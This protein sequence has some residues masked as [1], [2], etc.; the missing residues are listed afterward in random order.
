MNRLV[1][2]VELAERGAMRYTPAG[3]PALDLGLQHTSQV[4]EAGQPRKVS[5]SLRA[6]AL[7]DITRAL[8]A[9]PLGQAFD[10]AGFLTTHR[11]GRGL[12]FHIVEFV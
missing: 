4:I 7:G 11:N 9:M 10:A 2:S 3:V 8:A 6:L 1:L 5:M 12:V